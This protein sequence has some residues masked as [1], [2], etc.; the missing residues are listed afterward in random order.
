MSLLQAYVHQ[1]RHEAEGVLSVELRPAD[2]CDFPAFDAGAHI[3]LHLANG[4]IRNYSL[5]NPA[6]EAGRYVI[7]VL[8]DKASR[9]GSRYVHDTLRVGQRLPISAPRNNFPLHEDAPASVLV[10]GGIGITP[11]LCMAKRLKALGKP[12]ELMLFARSRANAAFLA[13]VH[14]LGVPLTLHF[15]DEQ[16]GPPDLKSLLARC[17]PGA[18]A[19]YYAC[20]PAVMLDTFEKACAELGYGHAHIER[21]APVEVKAASDARAN[22][23]VELK[24]T[25]RIIQITPEKSLLQT[26]L[27]SGVEVEY[28]CAEG[29]CGTCETRVLEG[30]PDHRDS[31]L[32]AKERAGNHCMMVCVSGCKSERLV[33]D[34]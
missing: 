27:D 25:G 12:F 8:R 17:A 9:G 1:M 23:S 28:S 34:L 30:H 16:G 6:G 4:L 3:D 29:V 11:I 7:G 31:V 22:Y 13:E 18:S 5:V 33:L 21:F 15:D 19:H 20:G 32:S 24:R 2:G 14:A 10:A 26:L